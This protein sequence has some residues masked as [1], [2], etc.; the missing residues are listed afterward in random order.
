MRQRT[1]CDF[2]L[3]VL[4]DGGW[5][6]TSEI[7][8]RSFVE[9]GHGMTVHSRVSDLR[10]KRGLEVEHRRAAG[11]R[12]DAFQ[13]RLAAS[14]AGAADPPSG[15]SSEPNEDEPV[16]AGS[17]FA[18]R[19][20]TFTRSEVAGSIPASRSPSPTPPAAP[21]TGL[22]EVIRL[23][24]YRGFL[25]ATDERIAELPDDSQQSLFDLLEEVA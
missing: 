15:S 2:L 12:A 16:T 11:E 14:S 13:Y 21:P 23:L 4:S 3:E 1:D 6:S 9:R 7:L 19:A 24:E 20:P 17:W 25:E 8:R 10:K 5:H 22:A 18:E